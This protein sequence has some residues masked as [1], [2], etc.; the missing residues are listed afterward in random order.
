MTGC[1]YTKVFEPDPKLL[2]DEGCIGSVTVIDDWIYYLHTK[3]LKIVTKIG[4]NEK[5]DIIPET[6]GPYRYSLV[7]GETQLIWPQDWQL[8]K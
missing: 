1:P 2:E 7:T 8:H 3:L 5:T 4:V 6:T